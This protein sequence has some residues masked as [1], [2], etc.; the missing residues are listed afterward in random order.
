[1]VVCSRCELRPVAASM[2][3]VQTF[4]LVRRGRS[5]TK[6]LVSDDTAVELDEVYSESSFEGK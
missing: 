4:R 1:V 3:L 5:R 6:E 2:E